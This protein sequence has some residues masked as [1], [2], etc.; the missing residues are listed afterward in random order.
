ML[1]LDKLNQK[2]AQLIQSG[3]KALGFYNGTTRGKPG[4][5]TKAAYKK[6]LAPRNIDPTFGEALAL[7]AESQVGEREEGNNGGVAVRKYQ[8]AT[9]LEPGAWPWCAAFVCWSFKEA[10]KKSVQ[11]INRP[12][13]AGAWDFENWA[14]KEGA[15]LIKPASDTLVKRGDIVVYTFS[16]IGIAV[17]DELDGKVDTVE[18]NTNT[19]GDREGDGVYRKTRK[20]SQIRSIIRI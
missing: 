14:T 18:G 15:E 4:P 5:K 13:T 19:G 20:K 6:F 12:R 11:V 10:L 2:D 17:S 7:A 3:L 16:H 8:N 9:W 1:N